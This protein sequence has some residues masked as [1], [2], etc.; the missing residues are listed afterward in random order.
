LA[1]RDVNGDGKADLIVANYGADVGVLLGNGDGTFQTAVDYAAGAGLQSLALADFNGDG[2]ADIAVADA[3]GNSI[4]ILL[5]QPAA[6]LS[7]AKTHTGA[8]VTQRQGA[9]TLTVSNSA[10]A[11]PTSGAVTVTDTP[12]AG[13]TVVSMSG[14]GWTCGSGNSCTRSDVLAPGASY[15][16]ITVTVE[17][18]TDAVS[19][20]VNQASVS[21]GSSPAATASDSTSLIQ[22]L[23]S[24]IALVSS[25][26]PSIY[27]HAVTLT[28]TVTPVSATG[29]VTFYDGTTML[30]AKPVSGGQAVLTTTLLASG[31][32]TLR[33]H[34]GGDGFDGASDSAPVVQVVTPVPAASFAAPIGY[35]VALSP[36]GVAVA[37]F[38]ADGKADLVVT[39]YFSNTV[40][41][42]LGNG[43]GSF[44]PPLTS[45]AGSYPRAV[46][47]GDFN[48]DGKADI[49]VG[50]DQEDTINVLLGN[51]D[52]TFR[53]PLTY[54]A[55]YWPASIAVGDFNGDGKA[56]LAVAYSGRYTVGI[57]L[58]NG[59]GTFQAPVDYTADAGPVAV[60]GG[61][62][63][64]D[65]KPDLA[66][67][68]A[69]NSSVS[70]LLGSGDGTFQTEVEYA[71]GLGPQEIVAADFNGDGKTDLAVADWFAGTIGVLLGVGDGTFQTAIFYPVGYTP[72]SL[73]AGDVNGD[74]KADLIFTNFDSSG[75][76][77]LLGVGD[78]T[79]LPPANYAAGSSPY[80]VAIGDFNGDGRADL[81][82]GGASVNV[83]LGTPTS[84]ALSIA[85]NHAGNFAQGQTGAAYSV[86]VSNGPGGAPTSGTV[87]LTETAPTGLTLVS[88]TG[89]GWTCPVGGNSCSRGDPLAAG[90]S[91]PPVVIAVDVAL[92]A[93]SPVV[94]QV[95]VSGGGS[96]SINASD[97][98]NV[99]IAY[100][101]G[102]VAP[103]TTDTAP[104]FGDGALNILDLVQE[105]FAVNGVPGFAPA[106]CSD[107][108]DAMDTYP[109]D[110]A[111]SRGGDGVLDIRDLI[112]ELFRVNSL[113]TSRPVR[114]SLGGALP[115]ATCATGPSGNSKRA[116]KVGRRPAGPQGPRAA[117]QG[118][119]VLGRTEQSNVTEERIPVYL[120]AA[121][122]LVRVAVTL[123][124]GDQQSQ[125]RFV[126]TAAA[127][128]LVQDGQLG[129]VAA[130]WLN[131]VTV[132]AGERLLL[133]YVEG[134]VG[135][136]ANLK[137]YG[138]S[139]SGL[140]DNREVSLEAPTAV[141]LGR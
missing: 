48:G 110:A 2:R 10:G 5:G 119:L 107:R 89:T 103:Y 23:T 44:Q 54:L 129:V 52:G 85:S 118:A 108:W 69:E 132:R 76:S 111:T 67:A 22:L 134:P 3:A 104:N 87:N 24:S 84:P 75:V 131:G 95:S 1:V 97:S 90:G 26:T 18:A 66:V 114:A 93:A 59:D 116:T 63:N 50:T 19:P 33:A 109:L 105:L 36:W 92:N 41:V 115:W 14:S 42:L 79:F 101:V 65:G 47:V 12:P 51:G 4:S 117:A 125:L 30:E 133:G 29:T 113:D 74:G 91:Y 80:S 20:L 35:T 121:Q 86:T 25:P 34:Y 126:P 37:D 16:P 73:T 98:T 88:M 45:A 21:G 62:F 140:D 28:A 9:Y 40:S 38:N 137:V 122:D 56:D 141:G 61:D 106:A 49:V 55:D 123:A 124:L 13:M 11:G 136:S 27:G 15:A 32:H 17:V 120:E 7:L 6:L 71:A 77:V 127:P 81:A 31:E 72:D 82:L 78:G 128:S 8:F 70:V 94:N 57:F 102:D 139:A 100:L 112:E 99:T 83:L 135:A 43:D 68:D 60:V 96:A 46:S 58:G 138:I 64:G 39:D 53:P 130:A